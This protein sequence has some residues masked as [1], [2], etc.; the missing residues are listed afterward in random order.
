MY[1]PKKRTIKPNQILSEKNHSY[2]I[3]MLQI[4]LI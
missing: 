2:L 4:K 3:K 1:V